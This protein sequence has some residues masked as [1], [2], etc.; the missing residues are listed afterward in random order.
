MAEAQLNLGILL[1]EKD[2]AAAV[3]PLRKAVDLLPAQSRPRFLLGLAAK[4]LG[5]FAGAG[6]II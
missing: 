4:R 2:P 1:L 3:A 6:R 5:D